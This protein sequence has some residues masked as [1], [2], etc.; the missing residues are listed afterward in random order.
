MFII[1]QD[2]KYVFSLPE[3]PAKRTQQRGGA[4]NIKSGDVCT[5]LHDPALPELPPAL[6]ALSTG[7]H[8]I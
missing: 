4:P 5:C 1:I 6:P 3:T 2:P 7:T 8:G